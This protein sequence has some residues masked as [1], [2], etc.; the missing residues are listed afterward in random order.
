MRVGFDKV[1]LYI[2][3]SILLIHTYKIF[4]YTSIINELYVSTYVEMW[5]KYEYSNIWIKN[6]MLY[7]NYI[8]YP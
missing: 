7:A 3:S 5:I 8:N 6:V 2:M 1:L 4:Y